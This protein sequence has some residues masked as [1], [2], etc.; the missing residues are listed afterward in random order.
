MDITSLLIARKYVDDSLASAIPAPASATVGQT[1]VVKEVDEEGK[2]I[3]WTAA[4]FPDSSQNGEDGFSP[5]A[6]VAQTGTGAVISITD[7]NGTTT[8]TVTNGADG[9]TP[10]IGENGNWFIGESDTGVSASGGT[11]SITVD[12]KLNKESTNPIQNKIVAEAVD[13]LSATINELRSELDENNVGSGSCFDIII[14]YDGTN[15]SAELTVGNYNTIIEK[16]N[17]KLPVFA[18]IYSFESTYKM[19]YDYPKYIEYI[20]EAGDFISVYN[21]I[22]DIQ[23]QI[24]PDN[25]ININYIG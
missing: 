8:A 11:T 17:N 9:K 2:P 6:T 18:M 3:A 12:D 19:Y 16:F 21:S 23:F 10:H 20:E 22:V 15:N 14:N 1:I 7:K 5:I 24:F 25:H 4:D 13:R